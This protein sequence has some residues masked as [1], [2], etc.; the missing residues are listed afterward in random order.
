V[1]HLPVARFD[2]R[3]DR[4]SFIRNDES[5]W[6]PAEVSALHEGLRNALAHLAGE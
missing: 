2:N 1:Y 6:K 4:T 5:A 3:I